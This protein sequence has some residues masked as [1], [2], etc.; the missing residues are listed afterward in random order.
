MEY[1]FRTYQKKVKKMLNYIWTGM[2][3]VGIIFGFINGRIDGVTK[4][5]FDGSKNAVELSITLLGII[6]LWSGLITVADKSGV[7]KYLAKILEPVISFLFPKLP[8]ENK[9][10]KS[11]V[12]NLT[13]NFLGL[14]NAATPFGIK[15]MKYLQEINTNKNECSS[16]MATFLI[17]NSIGLQLIPSTVISIRSSMGA[18]NPSDILYVVWIVSLA[19]LILSIVLTKLFNKLWRW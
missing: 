19:T 15:A 17:L 16:S 5:I 10:R 14:G 7:L 4:A 11:I 9:A 12:M 13:A 8:K 18:E 3:I 1:I 2:L 6:S